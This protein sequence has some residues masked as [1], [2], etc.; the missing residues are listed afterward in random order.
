LVHLDRGLLQLILHILLA[1]ASPSSSSAS[2]SSSSSAL[3][4]ELLLL[5]VLL[6]LEGGGLL[7]GRL[8]RAELVS[9]LLVLATSNLGSPMSFP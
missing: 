1:L 9:S 5:S 2:S 8:N 6:L 4:S 7:V 3:L